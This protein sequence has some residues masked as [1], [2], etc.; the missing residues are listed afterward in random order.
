MVS[1]FFDFGRNICKYDTT[2]KVCLPSSEKRCSGLGMAHFPDR[3]EPM[4][5]FSEKPVSIF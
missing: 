2:A 4:N 5:F 1:V 3:P